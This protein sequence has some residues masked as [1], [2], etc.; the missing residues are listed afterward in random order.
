MS[1]KEEKFE[2]HVFVKP[3]DSKQGC[4]ETSTIYVLHQKERTND[5]ISLEGTENNN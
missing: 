1:Y 5:S 4:R 2:E 3:A